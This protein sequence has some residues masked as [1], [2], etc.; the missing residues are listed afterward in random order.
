MANT[1]EVENSTPVP[2]E[3]KAVTAAPAKAKGRQAPTPEPEE[4][5]RPLRAEG[6]VPE[7]KRRVTLAGFWRDH[8]PGDEIDVDV[9]VAAAL[10]VGGYLVRS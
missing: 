2:D 1:Q 9:N 7:G 6:D 8:Q 4:V 10:D 3:N 5:E